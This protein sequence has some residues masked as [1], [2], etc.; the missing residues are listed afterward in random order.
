MPMRGSP[1]YTYYVIDIEEERDPVKARQMLKSLAE[2]SNS[3]K[4]II[5]LLQFEKRQ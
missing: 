4:P 1:E 3:L 5:S 2:H